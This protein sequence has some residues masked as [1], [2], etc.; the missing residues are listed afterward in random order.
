MKF[1]LYLFFILFSHSLFSQDTLYLIHLDSAQS[2]FEQGD[3]ELSKDQ[4]LKC[5]A[6]EDDYKRRDLYMLAQCLSA[7]GKLDSAFLFL[8]LALDLGLKGKDS[9]VLNKNEYLKALIDDSRW[10][11]IQRKFVINCSP[12][13]SIDTVLLNELLRRKDLDQQRSKRNKADWALQREV[14]SLNQIWLD[15]VVQ[16]KGWLTEPMVGVAGANA[17]WLIVQHADNNIAFQKSC[18]ALMKKKIRIG[19]IPLSQYAYLYDRVEINSCH[20]QVY[21]T[22]YAAI[23]DSGHRVKSI[24]F[25]PIKESAFVD[26]RRKYMRMVSLEKYRAFALKHYKNKKSTAQKGDAK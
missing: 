14:D 1:T 10:A 26:K 2:Y 21:G 16:K 7:Q 12:P 19:E 20:R 6:F 9:T 18:L 24:E 3:I 11:A 4:W 17:A 13:H 25:K 15:S 22:Q 5:I 23:Y 8:Q